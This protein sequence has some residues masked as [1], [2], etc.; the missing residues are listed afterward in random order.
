MENR[1]RAAGIAA[2][3]PPIVY[4]AGQSHLRRN[5]Y[6]KYIAG[7]TPVIFTAPHGGTLSPSSIAAVDLSAIHA[8]T[9][10]FLKA[11]IPEMR[12]G[13]GKGKTESG[14]YVNVWKQVHA[15]WKIQSHIWNAD[16]PRSN[17]H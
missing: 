3:V 8:L 7:N 17:V 14:K 5:G 4:V 12:E 9:V 15:S 6:V 16:S 13:Y 11:G 2:A 1:H 10:D